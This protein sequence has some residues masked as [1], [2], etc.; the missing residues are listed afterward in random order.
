LLNALRTC[1][2]EFKREREVT[3]WK[4]IRKSRALLDEFARGQGFDP[5]DVAGWT[6]APLEQ[7]LQAK[8][9]YYPMGFIFTYLFFTRA[10]MP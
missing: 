2:P 3:P 6:A 7:I 5:L 1:Y 4:D 9:I 8:V 10:G